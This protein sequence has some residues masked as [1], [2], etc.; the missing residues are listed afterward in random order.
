MRKNN[1]RYTLPIVIISTM[2]YFVVL[3]NSDYTNNSESYIEAE[4]IPSNSEQNYNKMMEVLTHKR[5]VNCHPSDGIPKQGEDSHPHY[6]GMARGEGNH[7]F[8]S[9]NCNTCHQDDNNDFSGVPGAPEWSLA[10]ASMMWEGLT[11]AEIAESMLDPARNG[12]RSHHEIEEHLT[13][14]AL[15]LW[16]WEPGIDAEGNPREAPPVPVDEYIEAVKAW[17]EEGA[18]IPQN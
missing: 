14:H 3:A 4:A 11:K 18:I 1:I 17:F 6:F 12:G 13:E 7:G 15:V 2:L 5:C 8:V 9:T 16:A 10:P